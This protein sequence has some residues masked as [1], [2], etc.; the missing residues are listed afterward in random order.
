MNENGLMIC[1]RLYDQNWES[2]ILLQTSPHRDDWH[3]FWTACRQKCVIIEFGCVPV[4][5]LLVY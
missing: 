2:V 3:D 4:N 5:G 1:W